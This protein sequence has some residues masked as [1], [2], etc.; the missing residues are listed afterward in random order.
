ET[1]PASEPGALSKGPGRLLVVGSSEMFGD[2]WIDKEDNAKLCDVLIR[3]LLGEAGVT[4]GRRREYDITDIADSRRVPNTEALADRLRCCLQET[5]ELPKKFTNLFNDRLFKFTT[6]MVPEAVA[7]YDHLGVKHEPL[8]LIP[9]QFESAFPPC[10]REPPPPALDQFDL[11][12]HFAGDK[13]RLAQITNKCT[14][15][16][17]DYYVSECGEILGVTGQLPEHGDRG[18]RAILDFV[19]KKLI[20]FKM[21]NQ[22]PGPLPQ[23]QDGS[24]GVAGGGGRGGFGRAGSTDHGSARRPPSSRGGGTGSSGDGAATDSALRG[25]RAGW[26]SAP[27]SSSGGSGGGTGGGGRRGED[28]GGRGGGGEVKDSSSGVRGAVDSRS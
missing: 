24:G 5:E 19:F 14:T 26:G 6:R 4:M 28:E 18:P 2:D 1:A 22:G 21:L 11:D 25:S 7:A 12:D 17:L 27:G 13:V 10:L 9:P 16:D 15:V 3:W 23:G 20:R 8:T